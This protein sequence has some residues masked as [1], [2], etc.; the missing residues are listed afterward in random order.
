MYVSHP[1]VD[2][3]RTSSTTIYATHNMLQTTQTRIPNTKYH[4]VSLF[5]VRDDATGEEEIIYGSEV[6]ERNKHNKI[7]FKGIPGHT[8]KHLKHICVLMFF[9]LTL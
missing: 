1:C 4:T 8:L 7:K 3:L 5:V 6:V 9:T 2:I